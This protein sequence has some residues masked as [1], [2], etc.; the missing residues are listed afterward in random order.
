MVSQ[1]ALVDKV[2][3]LLLDAATSLK[4]PVLLAAASR[5]QASADHFVKVR[6]IIKDLV[7]KLEADAAAEADHKSFCDKAIGEEVSA[8]DAANANIESL[9]SEK[10][11]LEAEMAKL[12]KEIAE[13]AKDIASLNKALKEATELRQNEKAE[14]EETIATAEEGKAGVEFA[15]KT[16]EDFYNAA[17]LQYTPP[18]SGRDGKTA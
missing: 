6:Q 1:V 17:F 4:S 14:N 9:T 11:K 3:K 8:R 18:N 13:L 12:A 7:S 10:S 16:L 5:T 15:I 2:A